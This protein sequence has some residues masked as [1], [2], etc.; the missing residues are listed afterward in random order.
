MRP[1][2][3][4]TYKNGGLYNKTRADL[5]SHCS[6]PEVQTSTETVTYCLLDSTQPSLRIYLSDPYW[7]L[8]F[9]ILTPDF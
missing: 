7:S 9:F 8:A 2:S 1:D 4:Y 6:C 5:S 3:P